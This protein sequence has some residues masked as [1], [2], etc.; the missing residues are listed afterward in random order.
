MENKEKAEAFIDEC[1]TFTSD[2]EEALEDCIGSLARIADEHNVVETVLVDTFCDLLKEH[3]GCKVRCDV[4]DA[5]EKML[6][7]S[8]EFGDQYLIA[9]KSD[10]VDENTIKD[11]FASYLETA[12]TADLSCAD[13]IDDVM[14][15]FVVTG[16]LTYR[17]VSFYHIAI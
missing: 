15:S 3:F 5:A 7:I 12:D 10:T 9:Y 11:A 4:S 6:V 2:C 8:F 1:V 16:E 13:I 14:Q 17:W